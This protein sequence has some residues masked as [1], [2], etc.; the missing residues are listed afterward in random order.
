MLCVQNELQGEIQEV[1]AVTQTMYDDGLSA[2]DD[3]KKGRE[4]DVFGDTGD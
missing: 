3:G 2:D 4:E 1:L